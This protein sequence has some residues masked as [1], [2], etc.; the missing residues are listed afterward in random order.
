MLSSRRTYRLSFFSVVHNSLINNTIRIK[1][2]SHFIINSLSFSLAPKRHFSTWTRCC[3][4][5]SSII[6]SSCVRVYT[7]LLL[8]LIFRL[9]HLLFQHLLRLRLNELSIDNNL[10]SLAI[11]ISCS[12]STCYIAVLAARNRQ[13]ILE[14]FLIHS[15][16]SGMLLCCN[17][18]SQIASID[19][20]FSICSLCCLRFN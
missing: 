10:T 13:T 15:C 16:M 14:Q 4:G 17:C 20:H 2:F 18:L 7:D 12:L 1:Q 3:H 19:R 11:S 8:R 6:V 5:T 9:L